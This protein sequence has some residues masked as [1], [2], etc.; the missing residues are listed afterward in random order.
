[1]NVFVYPQW[2]PGYDFRFLGTYKFATSWMKQ[3]ISVLA[4]E[5][6]ANYHETFFVQVR[7]NNSA[8][9][10]LSDP[11]NI[12][13]QR[14]YLDQTASY[15]DFTQPVTSNGLNIGMYQNEY[16]SV[17]TRTYAEQIA[18]VGEYFGGKL[19]SILGLRHDSNNRT[20][21]SNGINPDNS[22]SVTGQSQS[23]TATRGS[24]GFVY[25]PVSWVGPFFNYSE[26][27]SLPSLGSPLFDG[28][29][30]PPTN[31]RTKEAGLQ[32][33]FFSG[34]VQGRVS[35]YDS[36]ESGRLV[37]AP[38]INQVNDIWRRLGQTDQ[39]INGGRRDTQT[40][41]A[42]GFE[43]EFTANISQNWRAMLNFGFPKAFQ[44]D[45]YPGLKAYYAKNIAAWQ[46]GTTNPNLTPAAQQSIINDLT[47]I[48]VG[49]ENAHN[50]RAV[51]QSMKY[52]ANFFNNYTFTSGPLKHLSI[53]GGVN[54]FGP[55]VIG[56]VTGQPF[57][58]IYQKEY[59]L[60]SADIIYSNRIGKCHYKLQVNVTNLFNNK[61]LLYQNVL[62]PAGVSFDEP[63]AFYYIDPRKAVFST[64]FE[65]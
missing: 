65:F 7:T 29:Q 4:S 10:N 19:T 52:R 47:A 64:T 40:L 46:A 16:F 12:V 6:Y 35:Y 59:L 18:S 15:S 5:N 23:N 17:P 32:L 57:N 1:V 20:T 54:L 37:T 39:V 22:L 48:N 55:Q 33:K 34:Q 30:G 24:A 26:S 13:Y 63:N 38:A 49:I 27:Y 45:A 11:A 42:K 60:G 43:A 53:G 8:V 14:R 62:R 28:T 3:Q 61:T 31:G 56:N 9:P 25:Y 58:Y 41:Y 2:N 51:N 36:Q 50:G 21:Y 44:S